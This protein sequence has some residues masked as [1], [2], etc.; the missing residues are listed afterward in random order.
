M[1]GDR[2]FPALA[3][4]LW[5]QLLPPELRSVTSVNQFRAHLKRYLFKLA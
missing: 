1:Y 5:N 2:A 3:P 4:G